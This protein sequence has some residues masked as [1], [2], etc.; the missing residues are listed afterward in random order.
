MASYLE[1]IASHLEQKTKTMTNNN[2]NMHFILGNEA[3]DADSILSALTLGYVMTLEDHYYENGDDCI[4]RSGSCNKKNRR[5]VVPI[6][7]VPRVDLPLR[8]DVALLLEL[9][10]FSIAQLPCLDD[11]CIAARLEEPKEGLTLTLVDHN[12][13]RST[14]SHLS[15]LVTEI[16]DHHEDEGYHLE[17]T[18]PTTTILNKRV[19]AFEAGRATVASTCTL[20][21]ERLFALLT[22]ISKKNNAAL[23]STKIDG[24]LGLLL[25]GVILLDTINMSP[26]AGRGTLRD[27]QAITI[28]LE[29]T[30]WSSLHRQQHHLE[31]STA[32]TTTGVSEEPS[33]ELLQKRIFP[34]H[35]NG[36]SS[37]N[38]GGAPNVTALFELLSNSRSDKKYWMGASVSDC[39]RMDYKKFTVSSQSSS[40]SSQSPS[41]PIS[42]IGL[43]TVL[44]SMDDFMSKHNFCTDLSTYITLSD[45][46]LLGV[47]TLD[48]YEIDD[49]TTTAIRGLLLASFHREV[50]DSYTA[51]LLN[52]AEA[53][54][55]ELVECSSTEMAEKTNIDDI[56]CLI[57]VRVFQQGNARMGRKQIAPI[58]VGGATSVAEKIV[59]RKY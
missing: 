8:R 52:G 3:G 2:K 45:V 54:F 31:K 23:T 30:D 47:L 4:R 33:H 46:D 14:L 26:T 22:A 25:L 28:L 24:S 56:G 42:S 32:S 5:L 51:F 18:T 38:R 15:E 37:T 27:A 48:L 17:T 6:A 41:T 11:E 57:H 35:D 55:L 29:Q 20:V 7:S 59:P 19:I 10:G 53:A 36:D 9:S 44:L 34:N 58:L 43:S 50:V 49:G 13:I 12:R 39:L 16:L 21:V 40:S 1:S